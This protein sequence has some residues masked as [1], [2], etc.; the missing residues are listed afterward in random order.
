MNGI[1]LSGDVFR[2]CPRRFLKWVVQFSILFSD[3]PPLMVIGDRFFLRV[4]SFTVSHT[5]EHFFVIYKCDIS[6][7]FPSIYSAST[8]RYALS[9]VFKRFTQLIL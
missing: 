2:A 1:D 6:S 7:M 4:N 9:K 5:A 8:E 3:E